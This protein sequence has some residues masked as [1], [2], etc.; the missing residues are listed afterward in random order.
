[1]KTLPLL[2]DSRSRII[3]ALAVFPKTESHLRQLFEL[4]ESG[5]RSAQIILKDLQTAKIIT[6]IRRGNKLFYFLNQRHPNYQ[7][8]VNTFDQQTSELI[9]MRA[10]EYNDS[11]RQILDFISSAESLFNKVV[12]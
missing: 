3:K 12:E 10:P 5:M 4:S 6:A 9:R 1:M 7:Y 2:S 8:I 11:A